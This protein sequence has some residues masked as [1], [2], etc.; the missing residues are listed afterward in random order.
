[1]TGPP[2]ARALFASQA[3]AQGSGLLQTPSAF[4]S[5]AAA[6][7]LFRQQWRCQVRQ[8]SSHKQSE[9]KNGKVKLPT[10][11]QQ[12]PDAG[13]G[14]CRLRLRL[15]PLRYSQNVSLNC[16]LNAPANLSLPAPAETAR[17]SYSRRDSPHP[18]QR[19]CR[20]RASVHLRYH[21]LRSYA[22]IC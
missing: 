21:R 3:A 15:F 1:M 16:R 2:T 17:P 5:T 14:V 11:L 12:Q 8:P 9:G 22:G 19:S 7:P 13:F 20:R 18:Q 4:R 10:A 6:F